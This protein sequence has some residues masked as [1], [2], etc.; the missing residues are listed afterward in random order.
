LRD[1]QAGRAAIDVIRDPAK[2]GAVA[3][4]FPDTAD[5]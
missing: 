2:L 4:A 3:A 1:W 5:R